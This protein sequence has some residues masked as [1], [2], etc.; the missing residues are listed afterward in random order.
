MTTFVVDTVSVNDISLGNGGCLYGCRLLF[1][2][3]GTMDQPSQ[4]V[5]VDPMAPSTCS[6]PILNNYHG[7]PFNSLNDVIT[8]RHPH[9]STKLLIFFTDPTY[10]FEQGFRPQPQLPSHVYC[11]DPDIGDIRA[12][13]DGFC[14][15][16]GICFDPSGSVCYITDTGHIHGTG[17]IDP[18]K[19]STM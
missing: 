5:L 4:L 17:L 12:V 11:F 9:D 1:C 18:A 6:Q 16:N 7:R 19:T 15:P 13:A 8:L 14:H 3:Q 10:G 2:D